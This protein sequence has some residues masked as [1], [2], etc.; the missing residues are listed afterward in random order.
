MTSGG[1]GKR[2][3]VRAAVRA[4]VLCVALA[5]PHAT[6]A[7]D[8]D[9]VYV[10]Q[11]RY[12]DNAN[13]TWPEVAHPAR[14]DPGAD[15]MLLHPDGSEEVLVAGGVGAVTDPFVSFDGEWVYYSLF[16][17][18]RAEAVNYQRGLP[19]AGADIFRLHLATR[20][21]E[22]LTF[23][24]F[25]PN[26]GAGRFDESDP[27]DPGGQYDRLGYGILN[28]GA[29]PLPG[30]RI[31]FTSNRNGFV[32]PRGLTNPTL[33]LFVID[34]GGGNVTQIAPMNIGSALHP[35]PLRD[36]R[37]MFSTMETQ[38]LRDSRMWGIWAIWPDGRRWEPVV[39]AFHLGQAFHFMTQLSDTDL[40][41]TDYYNLN[42]NGFG[43]LFRMPVRPPPGTP[44]FFSAFPED[45]PPIAQI[46]GA[47]FSYPFTMPFTPYGFHAITPFTHPQDEAAPIGGDGQRVGKFTHPSAAPGNDLL[48]VW[49]PGPANDLN[50]PTTLPYYDGGLYLIP[51]GGPVQS[52]SALVPLKN[53]PNYNE[54][55]PRAVVSY[56]AVHG[57]D[58]PDALP[59]LPNDGTQHA[60]LPAGTPYGL[61]GSSSVYK[62]ESFPGFVRSWSDTFDGL[63]AFNTTENEQ[64]SNWGWQG[65]DAGTYANSDI[66]ALRVVAMEPGTHRSYGPNGGPSGGHFFS[67]H[68]MERLRILGEVP[69]RK[70]DVMGRTLLDPEGN[71]D[72]SFLV[73]LPADT[74]FTFQTLDRNGMVLNMAQTWHQVRPGEVRA[75]CGGCHAHS[76]QPLDFA[77]TAAA[78]ASYDVRDLSH[79]TPLLSRDAQ[80][81]P[82]LREVAAPQVTVE[83]IR[84]IRPILQRS[85]VPCHSGA[86]APGRLRL[87]DTGTVNGFL[88]GDYAR[89]ADDGHAQWGYPPVIGAGAGWRQTNASRY[90]RAFQSR[91]S[92]L[93]WKLYGQRLDGWSNADHPTEST[94]GDAATL[95]PGANPNFADLDFTGQ[96]MPPPGSGVPPLSED[97]RM[98]FARW[99][100]LGAPINWANGGANAYGWFL[101]DLRPA[102][103]V[104]L[105]RPGRNET[106]VTMFRLGA[107]D[108]HSGVDWPTLSITADFPVNGRPAGAQLADLAA[109]AGDGIRTLALETPLTA[110]ASGNL[111]VSVEDVQGNVTR[112]ARRFRVELAAGPSPTPSA[113]PPPSPTRSATRPPASATPSASA[114]RTPTRSATPTRTHTGTP[115]VGASLAG[116][117]RY[118]RGD[119]PLGGVGVAGAT[120]AADG[121][122]TVASGLGAA[123]TLRPQHFGALHGAVSALDASYVL[124]A[125]AA[126]R[127]FD[128]LESAACDATGNGTLSPLDATRI[129]ELTVGMR[130]RL[131]VAESCASDW[132]FSPDPAPAAG[133]QVTP[134]L[135]AGSCVPGA[136]AFAALPASAA[137][138]NFRAALFGDCT[139]NWQPAGAAAAMTRGAARARVT[140]GPALAA[141]GRLRVPIRVRGGSAVE[142]A[143]R[144]DPTRLRYAGAR[145]AGG[146]VLRAA[147]G[148]DGRLRLAAAAAGA[149]DRARLTVV[150][151]RLDPTATLR[152]V[153][154]YGARV[155]D[156]AV[157]STRTRR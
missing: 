149:L 113:T 125:V 63:D 94:P 75:D 87:D 41:V 93:M 145:A 21:I 88:P 68:A 119:R 27:V 86:D 38:G 43:A 22:Q 6:A 153:I 89:L 42:N 25:T 45:N 17:D 104:S 48:V 129:L 23:Q 49:S 123:V 29:A 16:Y 72:T 61:V 98:L 127:S 118:H 156:A 121:T 67:S 32:P 4:A 10:R 34:A 95:P 74:P 92:L 157:Y 147:A 109:S 101:D 24:E 79:T 60:A 8:Y 36:G 152:D 143:L 115:T 64:S 139:G 103:D 3:D 83:F 105:P 77:A 117:V 82:S 96:M 132:L 56:R 78:Q 53:D 144:A 5:L 33:Q 2:R 91:R 100:D 97:E 30:G 14:A 108:A 154:V 71:P 70:L 9:I 11:P 19:Y 130:A 65:A 124:Q 28:L 58:E 59:W 1:T 141:R 51:D 66:W 131:P 69:L 7:V 90:I 84:D 50:R 31:A 112:V 62:R 111:L 80:G 81:E 155:D 35:T 47:G 13:T 73:K 107:A 55:W 99:I 76:Q 54:A 120:T 128:A 44:P 20:T 114:T 136:I 142:L 46:I 52:P 116:R 137:G 18:M 57:V 26:T 122:F 37:L 133:Q 148:A 151:E 40:V 134:P 15:L 110:P 146:A 126:L 85:C 135:I 102:L 12:G 140:L 150:F 138:R 106:A 39:S